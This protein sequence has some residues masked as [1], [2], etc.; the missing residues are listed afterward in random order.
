M[1][2]ETG[3]IFNSMEDGVREAMSRGLTELEASA[4]LMPLE[5]A[6]YDHLKCMN[7][8]QRRRWARENKKKKV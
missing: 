5:S 8:A 1:N 3:E 4:Q 2:C 6:E 7:R